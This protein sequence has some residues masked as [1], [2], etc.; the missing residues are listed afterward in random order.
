[1]RLRHL[2]SRGRALLATLLLSGL[3]PVVTSAHEPGMV[4]LTLDRTTDTFRAEVDLVDLDYLIGLDVD[5]DGY[6]SAAEVGANRSRISRHVSR[7][8]SIDGCRIDSVF[9]R[10]GLR[11]DATPSVVVDYSLQCDSAGELTIAS[12]VFDELPDY[13]TVLILE[14]AGE[15]RAFVLGADQLSI[16]PD[17]TATSAGFG[18]FLREGVV[19]I[20]IGIDH[21]AFL[22]VLVL[23]LAT[24]GSWPQRLRA[25]AW[26]VTAF[27]IAHS[28]TL[29]LSAMGQLALPARPVELV[30][31]ASVVAAALLNLFAG[32]SLHRW[33][34]A[35]AF[36]LIHGFGFAGA[37]GELAIAD[38]LRISTLLAFNL[39]VELGQLL[40]VAIALPI[41]ALLARIERL[42]R[43]LV[44]A[45]S[46][47]VASL[48]I[49]WLVERF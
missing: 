20:L 16:A 31:A 17:E 24:R 18:T 27:T 45:G 12:T 10:T 7:G 36:G 3:L 34:L 42:G 11:R 22:L 1:M 23:P 43:V 2:F 4:E 35:Y 38:G 21:L 44:P 39:G 8:L 37:L 47:A 48:G 19:H 33:P 13:R 46:I 9:S 30:I 5:A 29:S 15:P 49:L 32:R 41:L 14:T 40:V 25:T 28:I 26:L 6:V